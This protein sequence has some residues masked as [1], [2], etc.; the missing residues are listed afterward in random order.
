VLA[1]SSSSAATAVAQQARSS[2]LAIA[3]RNLLLEP[4]FEHVQPQQWSTDAAASTTTTP[5]AATAEEEDGAA[6]WTGSGDGVDEAEQRSRAA[7]ILDPFAY[8]A[9]GSSK[10]IR[11]SVPSK[12]RPAD[13]TGE[14]AA[15]DAASISDQ[16]QS[17]ADT[18]LFMDFEPPQ[19]PS[20][21]SRRVLQA[22]SSPLASPSK[23]AVPSSPL[24]A[25]ASTM[26]HR[27]AESFAASGSV[28]RR[29]SS[30][31]K[32]LHGE[33]EAEPSPSATP[34]PSLAAVQPTDALL[35]LSKRPRTVDEQAACTC[36]HAA[37]DISSSSCTTAPALVFEAL[38]TTGQSMPA[39]TPSP[40]APDASAWPPGSAPSS[41]SAQL[42]PI[43][44]ER[45]ML[46]RAELVGQLDN[47]FL[48]CR[49]EGL[50]LAVDQHAADERRRLEFLQQRLTLYVQQVSL[51]QALPLPIS[52]AEE[53]VLRSH[54]AEIC[55]WGFRFRFPGALS[56][57]SASSSSRDAAS[58]SA[59][60]VSNRVLLTS[61]P[62]VCG[63]ELD[64]EDLRE[65]LQQLR[66]TKPLVPTAT[67]KLNAT[68]AS[69]A[70]ASPPSPLTGFLSRT[71]LPVQRIL[72]YKACRSSVMFGDTLPLAS[73]RAILRGLRQ[74]D[75]PFNC[76]HGRP[77]MTPLVH[78]Q[79][80]QRQAD[81]DKQKRG[82]GED[83]AAIWTAEDHASL[84]DLLTPAH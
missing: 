17:F 51:L 69:D 3:Q 19:P 28:G 38:P 21:P 80:L 83:A 84:L 67:S 44:L 46:L 11:G 49:V 56:S 74:C 33:L 79:P 9:R 58:R 35:P 64:V 82:S 25:A 53:S 66:D 76:A 43:A 22:Q 30:G 59:A 27:S 24:V 78:V 52:S 50:L 70:L 18:A 10:H 75:F 62:L 42:H 13:T 47:K 60:L 26:T 5:M 41:T 34:M 14:G 61:V 68:A 77:T 6:E 36:P 20:S 63:V 72:N 12:E 29:S 23:Q 71:P 37:H 55:A 57:A 8:P 16:G 32:R 54:E 7:P 45:D 48:V 65:Y 81:E 2:A 40:P 4:M 31:R 73:M 1:S 15:T 39:R